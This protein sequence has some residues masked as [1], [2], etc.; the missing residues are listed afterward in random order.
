MK[1]S[2]ATEAMCNQHHGAGS[3]GSMDSASSFRIVRCDGIPALNI[4][5]QTKQADTKKRLIFSF[6]ELPEVQESLRERDE[7]RAAVR[8]T[9]AQE[10][11]DV[12]V[13][14]LRELVIRVL[15]KLNED[16]SSRGEDE[17]RSEAADQKP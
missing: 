15:Q 1:R 11:L 14:R 3:F 8:E 2:E 16:G 7:V 5:K 12:Q 13:K 4:E 9:L 6:K 17:A 10:P